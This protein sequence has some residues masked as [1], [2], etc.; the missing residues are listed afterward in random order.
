MSES[1][2]SRQVI[3]HQADLAARMYLA[4]GEGAQRPTAPYCPHLEPQ[5][6]QEWQASFSRALH[7]LRAV[8]G[9]EASA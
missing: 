5:H 9:S 1:I 2:V 3:A 7:N 6:W 4:A 8:E